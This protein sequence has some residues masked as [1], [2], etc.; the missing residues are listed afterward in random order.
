MKIKEE[1][2]EYYLLRDFLDEVNS[3]LEGR[4]NDIDCDQYLYKELLKKRYSSVLEHHFS[5][6]SCL[7]RQQKALLRLLSMKKF[8]K[9]RYEK[10]RVCQKKLDTLSDNAT[11]VAFTK[12]TKNRKCYSYKSVRAHRKCSRLVRIPKG[13]KKLSAESSNA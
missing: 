11:I 5:C 7:H 3:A 10:C 2:E 9:F 13:W 8:R 12:P 4:C 6:M 1:R